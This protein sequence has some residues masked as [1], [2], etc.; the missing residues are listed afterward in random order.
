MFLH[1]VCCSRGHKLDK[2][3]TATEHACRKVQS[4]LHAHK[5]YHMPTG[6]PQTFCDKIPGLFQDFFRTKYVFS[7]TL[8]CYKLKH[9]CSQ[10]TKN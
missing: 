10:V 3:P 5:K 4:N 6:F 1:N 2:V 7:R 8:M 9:F